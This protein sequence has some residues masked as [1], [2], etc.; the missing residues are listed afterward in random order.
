MD[1]LLSGTHR[2]P[3]SLH[4]I[5]GGNH[6]LL[7]PRRGELAFNDKCFLTHARR[8]TYSPQS[9]FCEVNQQLMFLTRSEYGKRC[10]ATDPLY[11]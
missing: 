1:P 4:S 8:V 2:P 3:R 10:G 9:L 7:H 6:H 11:F 5:G